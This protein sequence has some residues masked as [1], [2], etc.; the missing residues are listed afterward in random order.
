MGAREMRRPSRVVERLRV[1]EQDQRSVSGERVLDRWRVRGDG[2][3]RVV[4]GAREPVG[5]TPPDPSK[6]LQLLRARRERGRPGA[7]DAV[8][9]TGEGELPWMAQDDVSV[10]S[11]GRTEADGGPEGEVVDEDRVLVGPV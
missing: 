3:Q 1:I 4:V 11:S 8:G 7:R 2:S 10:R 9:L 5:D 6:V